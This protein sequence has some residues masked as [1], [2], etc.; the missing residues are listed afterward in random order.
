M[1]SVTMVFSNMVRRSFALVL[2]LFGTGLLL[3]A[4]A[5]LSTPSPQEIQNI[6]QKFTQKETE[7][8][9]ARENYTYRQTNEILELD[10]DGQPSGG[11][12]KMVEEIS[13]DDRNRRTEHVL[14]APVPTLVKIMMTPEDEQDMIN[15]MPFVMT[16]DT[17]DAY[18]ITYVGHE[19]VDEVTC[20]VF[21]IKPKALTKNGKRY[22]EGQAW[23]D[24]RD[25]QIVKT[26]G[27]STGFLRRHDDQRFPRFTTYREQ[28]DGKYWFPTYTYADDTLNF[29]SGPQRIKEIIKYDQYK[30][31]EFKT[32]ST[33]QYGQVGVTPDQQSPNSNKP[34]DNLAPPLAPTR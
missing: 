28:I 11:S 8:A 17:A 7:F 30:K 5:A 16:T 33:I 21:S 23:V 18:D 12:Y 19:P 27:R 32:N 4:A 9:K 20:Y 26:Y 25:L 22:F 10:S 31:F 6:I 24:D 2:C 34:D 15:V 13:F 3:N 1:E 14:N 29:S